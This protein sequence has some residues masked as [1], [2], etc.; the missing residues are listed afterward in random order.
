MFLKMTVQFKLRYASLMRLADYELCFLV[1]SKRYFSTLL[2]I[3]FAINCVFHFVVLLRMSTARRFS[4]SQNSRALSE[5][6]AVHLCL[7]D[8]DRDVRSHQFHGARGADAEKVIMGYRIILSRKLV[9]SPAEATT[10]QLFHIY[11]STES[12]SA[13]PSNGSTNCCN[14]GTA[15]PPLLCLSRSPNDAPLKGLAIMYQMSPQGANLHKAFSRVPVMAPGP[16][17][18]LECQA[19]AGVIRGRRYQQPHFHITANADPY[20]RCYEHNVVSVSRLACKNSFRIDPI[21]LPTHHTDLIISRSL[22]LSS[23]SSYSPGAVNLCA[24]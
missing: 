3:K 1:C 4:L 6:D 18:A 8:V 20:L 17:G 11:Y 16:N 24:L 23:A 22:V 14:G 7:T 19:W 13:D 2:S 12:Q 10:S 15:A 9:H 5:L 21:L